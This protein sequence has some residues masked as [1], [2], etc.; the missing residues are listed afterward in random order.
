MTALLAIFQLAAQVLP[1][2]ASLVNQA[3]EAH[4]AG[5]QATLDALHD[6]AVAAAAALAP[7]VAQP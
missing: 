7:V 1:Q 4:Q 2:W 5:D 3:L 6:R